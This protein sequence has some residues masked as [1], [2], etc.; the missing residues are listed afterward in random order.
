MRFVKSSTCRAEAGVAL[1]AWK[2]AR[3]SPARHWPHPIQA[4]GTATPNAAEFLASCMRQAHQNL[5]FQPCAQLPQA[6]FSIDTD[7][8]AQPSPFSRA[9]LSSNSA[10]CTAVE[11]GG[12][13]LRHAL[14]CDRLTVEQEARASKLTWWSTPRDESRH[15]K[16]ASSWHA[17][18][19]AV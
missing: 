2:A 9:A 3:T 11:P 19:G 5:R 18:P 4:S 15:T 12:Q 17:R 16:V 7:S 8:C 10:E 6:S 13:Y 14:G 1:S